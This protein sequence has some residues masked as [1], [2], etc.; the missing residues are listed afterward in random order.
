MVTP[1]AEDI[2]NHFSLVLGSLFPV[3]L[4]PGTGT[5]AT[6]HPHRAAPYKP[7][8]ARS[9]LP[10]KRSGTDKQDSL[11]SQ[12]RSWHRALDTH[13]PNGQRVKASKAS[14]SE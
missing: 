7:A 3:P 9:Y 5:Q 4:H 2:W 13:G 1:H 6:P 14:P 10:Q 12:D 11:G 8:R